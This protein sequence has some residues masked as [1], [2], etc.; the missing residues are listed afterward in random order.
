MPRLSEA[1]LHKRERRD[2]PRLRS[3]EDTA[4]KLDVHPRTVDRLVRRGKLRG[5]K[6]GSRMMIDDASTDDLI[7]NGGE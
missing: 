1:T 5:V 3:R 2:R 6:I 4:Y 7:A